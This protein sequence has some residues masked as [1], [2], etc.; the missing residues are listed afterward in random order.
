M[1]E[2]RLAQE[3][4]VRFPTRPMSVVRMP[5]T[6]TARA[7]HRVELDGPTSAADGELGLVIFRT[8][9]KVDRNERLDAISEAH[10]RLGDREPSGVGLGVLAAH[11]KL[12]GYE[13]EGEA[14]A[15]LRVDHRTKD[16]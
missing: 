12:E 13:L 6:Q 7:R 9:Q 3:V 4:D 1:V 2:A 14:R 11:E 5:S 10:V 15:L 8:R 16:V